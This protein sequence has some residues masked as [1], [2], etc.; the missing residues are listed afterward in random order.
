MMK[1]AT[2]F[3]VLLVF[4][5]FQAVADCGDKQS[6]A[7]NAATNK[8]TVTVT[9]AAPVKQG[10]KV[11]V[12]IGETKMEAVVESV[13]DFL[14]FS[15]ITFTEPLLPGLR[16][17]NAPEFSSNS[18]KMEFKDGTGAAKSLDLCVA[19]TLNIRQRSMH[20]GGAVGENGKKADGTVLS[21]AAAASGDAHPGAMRFQYSESMTRFIPRNPNAKVVPSSNNMEEEFSVSVD[22]TDRKDPAFTDDN[23]IS[24]AFYLPRYSNSI[25]N[26]VR[27]G[28]RGEFAHAFHGDGRNTDVTLT[29]DGWFVPAQAL[30]I[31]SNSRYKT[32][33]L[34]FQL[35]AGRRSQNVA[36][37]RSTGNLAEGVLA[38]H[39]YLFDNYRV[40]FDYKTLFNGASKS[41]TSSAEAS[42][43]TQHSY[44]VSVNFLE[45]SKFSA[46]A[47]FES[48]H[49]GP[50]FTKL[51]QYFVG[52]G[53]Q[54]LLATTQEKSP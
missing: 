38:Y 19:D 12:T 43:R 2:L 36:G 50:I 4:S 9:G 20:V 49:S 24:G 30:T 51:R 18:A 16:G 21:A 41:S 31:F 26:R 52:V 53:L 37:K 54:N 13:K 5:A 35:S 17:T 47:S 6:I 10:D 1:R 34:S 33:P 14:G 45:K 11:T 15:L 27:G 28:V 8:A 48:G 29:A 40:D 39:L 3:F 42:P 7:F 32:L 22:T 23:R 46:V 44:K 25:L